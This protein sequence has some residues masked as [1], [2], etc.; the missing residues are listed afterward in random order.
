MACHGNVSM[1]CPIQ[2]WCVCQWAFATYIQK[3][4][5]C[6]HIQSI[7]CDAVNIQAL[8]AY[9]GSRQKHHIAA[10]K[11]IETKCGLSES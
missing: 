10:L 1:L 9:R 5:G 3:A 6:E 4:G 8:I 11:C 7:Q 2:N